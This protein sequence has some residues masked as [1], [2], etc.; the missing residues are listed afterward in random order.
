MDRSSQA[1]LYPQ[2]LARVYADTGFSF[3]KRRFRKI[4]AS[5]QQD[6][7]TQGRWSTLA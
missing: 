1:A 7:E 2:L 4:V 5:G 3:T 6:Y